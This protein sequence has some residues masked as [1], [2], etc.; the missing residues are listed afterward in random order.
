[1]TEEE[2]RE[3]MK[4]QEEID[5]KIYVIE[6]HIVINVLGNVESEYNIPLIGCS[7]PQGILG[8]V[9]HLTEKTWM[10]PKLVRR[11][12]DVACKQ[13]NIDIFM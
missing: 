4:S 10:T 13:S 11:F 6:G 12:I 9:R 2:V 8:W 7:T 3:I 1:M 5:K